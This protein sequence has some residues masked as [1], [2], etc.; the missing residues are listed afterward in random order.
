MNR[1]HLLNSAACLIPGLSVS[2]TQAVEAILNSRNDK[3]MLD[4]L[5]IC[6]ER[7]DWQGEVSEWRDRLFQVVDRIQSVIE[8][9]GSESE[10]LLM[11]AHQ[12]D[13]TADLCRGAQTGSKEKIIECALRFGEAFNLRLSVKNCGLKLEKE[14]SLNKLR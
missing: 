4:L 5:R 6:L 7:I 2:H 8:G 12:M 3:V 1:R 10:A 9:Q 14:K 11:T 13:V